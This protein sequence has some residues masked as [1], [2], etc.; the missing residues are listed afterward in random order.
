M[1]YRQTLESPWPLDLLSLKARC[2]V[3]KDTGCWIWQGARTNKGYGCVDVNGTN[4]TAH[5]AAWVAKFGSISK[6]IL[7]C[8]HCDTPPCINPDH[9]FLGTAK[10]NAAD[11]VS[12]G[13]HNSGSWKVLTEAVIAEARSFYLA[14]HTLAE[15]GKR[16]DVHP[17]AIA[18]ALHKY[19][20][21]TVRARGGARRKQLSA[22]P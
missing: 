8:H 18:W 21:G 14:G 12:K 16:F 22:S 9:L 2:I 19:H 3:F 5:R 17:T 1:T 10:D 6:G 7:V 11:M 20:P 4:T 13:R 15:T